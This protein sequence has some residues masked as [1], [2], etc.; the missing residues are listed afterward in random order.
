MTQ[1]TTILSIGLLA[2]AL[3]QGGIVYAADKIY[4]PY[5][6]PDELEIEYFGSRSDE[7]AQKQ[8][9]SIGY[10]VNE[11]WKTELYGKFAKDS[12]DNLKFDAWEW[13]NIFQLTE[14]G[15]YMVDVGAALS[16]EWTP[17]SNHADAIEARLILAKDIDKTSHILNINGEKQVGSGPREQLEGKVL[18]SSRYNYMREFDPGFEVESDF[19]EL[20]HMGSFDNQKHYFGPSAYGKLPLHLTDKGDALKYRVAYLFGVSDAADDGQAI[21]QL[22]YELHF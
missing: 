20:K 15:D 13:E 22:E 3:L 1:R 16:Y 19:G 4:S 11:Y 18:W 6:T 14:R 5:V 8:Q 7:D 10:G 2:I 9:F 12:G 21:V 17:Q